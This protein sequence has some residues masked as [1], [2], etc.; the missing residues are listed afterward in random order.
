MSVQWT[1]AGA[2]A[3]SRMFVALLLLAYSGIP[4]VTAF[5]EHDFKACSMRADFCSSR[6]LMTVSHLTCKELHDPPAGG[7]SK[8]AHLPLHMHRVAFGW[9]TVETTSAYVR[10]GAEM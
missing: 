10:A 2:A 7:S 6:N 5:K 4:G 9:C 3:T 8:L 1:M